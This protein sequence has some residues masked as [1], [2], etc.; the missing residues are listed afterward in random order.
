MKYEIENMKKIIGDQCLVINV[1]KKIAKDDRVIIIYEKQKMTMSEIP[2]I[3]GIPYQNTIKSRI[4]KC[5]NS[6][7]FN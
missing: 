1:F 2:S 3:S 6:R 4:K 5:I 7:S